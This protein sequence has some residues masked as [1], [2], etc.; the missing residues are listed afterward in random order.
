MPNLIQRDLYEDMLEEHHACEIN[1]FVC[2]PPL[3]QCGIRRQ[4]NPK[5]IIP[6]VVEQRIK[7]KAVKKQMQRN[8]ANNKKYSEVFREECR[9]STQRR[10][11]ITLADINEIEG[12]YQDSEYAWDMNW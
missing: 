12:V 6:E 3:K 11:L 5:K 9:A 10:Q 7:D 4:N 1:D 2:K 8:I